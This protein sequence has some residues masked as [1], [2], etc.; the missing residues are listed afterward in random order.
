[1][2]KDKLK[3]L[4]RL[5]F[6]S[7]IHIWYFKYREHMRYIESLKTQQPIDII[8]LLVDH[9]EPAK[10][11][12]VKGIEKVNDWCNNY[13]KIAQNFVDSDGIHP[14]HTWFY[15]Y[16]YPNFLILNVLSEYVFEEYGEI[17][18]HLHHGFDTSKSFREKIRNG[19][20]W[21]NSS[22]AM[23]TAEEIP[24]KQFAYIA[25]NWALDNGRKDARFSG[26]NDEIKILKECNCYA[27]FTF[28]SIETRAQPRMV[29]SIYYAKDNPRKPKSYNKG[30]NLKIGR[31]PSGDLLIFTGPVYIDWR[32][33]YIETASIE[34]FA[35][36]EM[37][38]I[39]YW[40]NANIHV[41]GRPEWL[42]VKLHTHGMQ[43]SN[44]YKDYDNFYQLC[45]DLDKEIKIN[46]GYRLHYVTAREAY[47]IAKA[48]EAGYHGNPNDY[49]NFLIKEPINKKI[50]CNQPYSLSKYSSN[51]IELHIKNKTNSLIKILFKEMPL[52]KIEGSN[53]EKIILFNENALY[54]DISGSDVCEIL[55][56]NN[57]VIKLKLPFKG[58]VAI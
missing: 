31:N 22:G 51:E 5:L 57:K 37:R 12:K 40:L 19:V 3:I 36:H 39:K 10:K 35:L 21:F 7:N 41:K 42:F 20:D 28:P 34:T 48:A 45:S 17:E 32:N 4:R 29:N 38:R 13:K 25:G 47:N 58:E 49:R 8:F 33:N 53:I 44:I 1:M 18:F 52:K 56:R 16:D 46:S 50:Y 55:F 54:L 23:I 6:L 11:D 43:S 9:F 15:R 27:D 2:V 14:Q 24:K 30:V 26:V